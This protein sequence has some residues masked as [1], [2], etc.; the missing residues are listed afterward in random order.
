V[1][2]HPR[3][4]EHDAGLGHP[5][6]PERLVAV[7]AGIAASGAADGVIWFEP[8]PASFDAIAAVHPGRYL[9]ALEEFAVAGGGH[10]DADTVLGPGSYDAALV[11]A[12]AGLEA[13]DRLRRGEADV[14]LC[15]V[16][17]PG[18]HATPR[19]PMGFCLVNNV[20]VAARALAD[21]GE[22]VLVVDYDAHHGNGTQDAF[23][24][25]PDVFYVSTH[26]YPLYPGTGALEEMG[27]GAGTGTTVNFP[28]PAGATGDVVLAA[29]DE[30]VAGIVDAWTPTWLLVSAGFDAHRCDPLTG[31][32]LAAGDFAA[33]TARLASYVPAG[34]TVLFL[35]GGYDLAAL[36]H[37]VAATVA[38][39]AGVEPDTRR[40]P[41]LADDL[42]TTSGGPGRPVVD[43]VARRR[44]ILGLDELL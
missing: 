22:R 14:A 30:V 31:L 24:D 29:L 9:L 25:D 1:A 16:R 8:S 17:P 35:E 23:Y 3:Y 38:A 27:A 21:S 43:G 41:D 26:E 37:S 39:L 42:H 15:A 12:G 18:H 5:E 20:A 19:R 6:R 28:L 40:R 33:I 44:R 10:L 36:T 2:T 11:A 32:G 13:I 7:H 34:R 4:A